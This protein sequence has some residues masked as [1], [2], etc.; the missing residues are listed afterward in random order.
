Q[1]N[2]LITEVNNAVAEVIASSITLQDAVLSGIIGNTG[3]QSRI[4]L[5]ALYASISSVTTVSGRVTVLETLT[6]DPGRLGINTLK[7]QI[8]QAVIRST[9]INVLDYG[10]MGDGVT[11][12]TA[13]IQAAINA[14]QPGQC[15]IFPYTGSG[16][17]YKISS[18][19]TVTTQNTWF[20]GSPRDAYAV[21]IRTGST[22]MVMLDIRAAGFVMR[23]M[24]LIG[25]LDLNSAYLNGASC[26]NT[27]MTL[28][29]D[30]DGNVDCDLQGATFQYLAL[31]ILLAGRNSNIRNSLFSSCRAGIKHDGPAAWQTGPDITQNRGH[32]IVGNRFHNIGTVITDKA[33]EFT[34]NAQLLSLL[35]Y[36]NFFD[37]LGLGSH[38]NI[39]GS[40]AVTARGVS[41]IGNKHTE[42]YAEAY[43]L[44][45]CDYPHIGEFDFIGNTA[46]GPASSAIV[47]T[48]CTYP[49]IEGGVL[50]YVWRNG[51]FGT[52]NS[53]VMINN[54]QI[55]QVGLHATLKGDALNF[56]NTNSNVRVN[57][58]MAT[59]IG[60][61]FFNGS[62]GGALNSLQ[63][64]SYASSVAGIL[65]TTM[66]LSSMRGQNKYVEGQYGKIEDIGYGQYTMASGV[67]RTLATVT[68]G[69]NYG[70]FVVEIELTGRDAASGN[71]YFVGKRIVRPENG[72]N[73]VTVAGTD[74]N[75][76][77]T[78]TFVASGTAGIA[79]QV[80]ANSAMQLG[81]RIRAT[82]GGAPAGAASQGV[83][84]AMLAQ[85]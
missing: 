58:V 72:A 24:S 74:G 6:A 85:P 52:G 34:L 35:V 21:S 14:A 23:N 30:S 59:T 17:F 33:I 22:T 49:L 11:D 38:I 8:S 32:N 10:A 18:T 61:A 19:L 83:T 27:G 69:N 54:I 2:D 3:S 5:D 75:A 70:A 26:T 82:S 46:T 77:L 15:I 63:N 4:A 37:S 66:L 1:I 68:S 57:N 9:G 44:N 43:N 64:C 51:I 62:P 53:N 48:N 55:L 36:N 16:K 41:L 60:N 39:S 28:S 84:V 80:T 42:A 76:G 47:L 81:A 40:S 78:V 71:A 79:I 65:S 45:Y 56:D 31:G 73:V 7:N 67:A 50:R 29:G 13:A 25:T 12:D 20:E